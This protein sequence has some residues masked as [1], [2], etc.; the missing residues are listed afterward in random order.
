MNI[1]PLSFVIYS[2]CSLFFV[3]FGKGTL[4]LAIG[5]HVLISVWS[6]QHSDTACT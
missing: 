6:S 1:E 3:L 4:Y 5:L 2:S